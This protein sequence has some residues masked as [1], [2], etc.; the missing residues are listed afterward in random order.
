MTAYYVSGEI[1]SLGQDYSPLPNA[2]GR[3]VSLAP[4]SNAA[5]FDLHF[6]N[7]VLLAMG[8]NRPGP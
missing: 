2:A 3:R 1:L 7:Q 5:P 6:M 4:G 8:Y